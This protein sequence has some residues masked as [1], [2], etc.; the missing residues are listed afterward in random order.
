MAGKVRVPFRRRYA[1][2]RAIFGQSWRV[3]RSERDLWVFPLLGF[4][5]MLLVL[6]PV[7]LLALLGG[8]GWV[9]AFAGLGPALAPLAVLVLLPL[10]YPFAVLAS[11]FNAA[12]CFAAYERMEGRA[13]TKREAWRRA[14]SQ[15]GP[16]AR[17]NALAMLVSGLLSVVG[18]LLDK[19]RIVPYLGQAVQALGAFAWAAASYFVIPI[20]VV[21]RERSALDALRSSVGLARGQW[22]KATAGI[23]TVA[24]AVLVPLLAAMLLLVVP[25]MLLPFAGRAFLAAFTVLM[26]AFVLAVFAVSVLSGTMGQVYQVAL[27]RYARSGIVSLPYTPETL[28]DA[29][30]PYREK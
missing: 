18:Q 16:I 2:S 10:F 3:L 21:E 19:L 23:V 5:S 8:W 12:L 25:M 26:G 4:A 24:L 7:L 29:W 20:L 17:F 6:V 22:G 9:A 27:Y 30:E 14:V 15:L 13:G 1:M 11:L 28:V